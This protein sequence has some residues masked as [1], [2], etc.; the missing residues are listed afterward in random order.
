MAT[1]WLT[2]VIHAVDPGLALLHQLRLEAAVPVARH[3]KRHLAVRALHP[4]RRNPV[5][6]VGLFGRWLYA[7][8]ITQMRGQLGPEHPFHKPDLQFLHQPGQSSGK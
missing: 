8:L 2:L 3:R 1:R 7:S 6:A 5:P 4:L